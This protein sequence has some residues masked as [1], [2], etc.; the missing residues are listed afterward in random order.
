MGVYCVSIV[1]FH[2]AREGVVVVTISGSD[3]KGGCVGGLD[4]DVARCGCDLRVLTRGL[5]CCVV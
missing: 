3:W 2:M 5:F 1:R 4:G